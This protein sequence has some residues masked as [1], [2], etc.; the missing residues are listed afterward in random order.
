M[1]MKNVAML[2]GAL[3][4]NCFGPGPLSLDALMKPVSR[5]TRGAALSPHPES[6]SLEKTT[7]RSFGDPAAS[8]TSSA[9]LPMGVTTRPDAATVNQSERVPVSDQTPGRPQVSGAADCGASPMRPCVHVDGTIARI[10]SEYLEMPDLRLTP[11]QVAR[12]CGVEGLPCQRALDR[13][14]QAKFLRIRSDGTYVR[15]GG[16][17]DRPW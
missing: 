12:L 6:R 16:G 4:I 9:S 11:A 17:L 7:T 5:N 3:L 1:F 15:F 13:L 2:G 14:V 10:R 8:M